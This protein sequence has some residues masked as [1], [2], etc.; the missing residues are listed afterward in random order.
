MAN[1]DVTMSNDW[2]TYKLKDLTSAL[3]TDEKVEAK[4]H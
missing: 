2:R 4:K 3:D 1:S